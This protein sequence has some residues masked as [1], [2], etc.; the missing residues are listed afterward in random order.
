MSIYPI[1][2]RILFQER[3]GSTT[4]VK[5]LKKVHVGRNV[6]GSGDTI[7]TKTSLFFFR[8]SRWGRRGGLYAVLYGTCTCK[9][10]AYALFDVCVAL[11]D[12]E[13]LKL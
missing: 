9:C 7:V 1:P 3:N 10:T 13:C 5:T 6:Y 11:S 12:A 2:N 4:T 8:V